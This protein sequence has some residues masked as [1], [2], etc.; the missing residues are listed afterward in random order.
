MDA[1]EKAKSGHPGMPMGCAPMAF[2]LWDRHLKHAPRSPKW[3]DRDRFVLS[4]G[5]GSMLLYA[6]LHLTGYAVALDDLKNFRQWGSITPGHPEN[7][8]TPGVEMATGPLGQGISTAVGMAIAEANLAARFNK[9]E[10]EIVDHFTYVIASDGD[11]MEGVAQEAC[12]LAGHLG[13]GKLVVLYDDNSI[14]I[15]GNTHLSF[16]ENTGQKFEAMGWHI[17]HIDGMDCEAVDRAL[18]EAKAVTDKPSL[19]AARTII[20]FGSPNKAN[21]EKSHGSP[22]G[23]DELKLAKEVLGLPVDQSFWIPAAAAE[24]FGAAGEAGEG[25]VAEW[26]GR[27]SRYAAEYPELAAEWQA[28][29]DGTPL[30]NWTESFEAPTSPTASRA[31]N[32]VAVQLV[33]KAYPG[34]MGGS[35]D[36]T[37]NVMT[38]IKGN[39]Y[40][41][42]ENQ[43]GR[44]LNF[45]VREHAMAAA[46]NGMT[47]HGGTR[48][49]AGT[50]FIFSD[51]CRPSIRLAALMHC[52]TVFCFSHDSIGLGEDGPTH[53]PVEHLMSCRAI[54]NFNVFRPADANETIVAWK[55]A[56]EAKDFPTAIVTSRQ[57]LPVVSPASVGDHPAEKGGYV[58]KQVA[59]PQACLVATGSE[60]GLAMEA[61]AALDAEGIATR[62]VSL[63]SWYLFERQSAEYRDSVLEDGLPTVSIEAGV[64][65]GWAKYADAHVGLDRFGASA[66]ADVNFRELGFTVENVVA[67]VKGLLG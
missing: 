22:L 41:S 65:L 11:L 17:Q 2:T 4:A 12:S 20:G 46:A 15:D 18:V 19:I 61:A 48:G 3:A 56:M 42:P 25:L 52:P 6:L 21:S 14:T 38:E 49:M 45:G 59:Q 26:N 57:A 29:W 24:R 28:M 30:I 8:H 23:A 47:M 10:H 7:T 44:N 32:G 50:F 67:T 13:L 66:P 33:A 37:H 36:L 16:T 31:T 51:Y 27:L 60:V 43:A 58:L 1:V 5:H 9:P 40:F 34:L 53:Q 63:P 55:V 64:T 35:A 62:V 39:G 54:P